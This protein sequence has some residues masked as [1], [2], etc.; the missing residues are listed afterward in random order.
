MAVKQVGDWL[1]EFSQS[2]GMAML[3]LRNQLHSETI[4]VEAFP[5]SMVEQ[6]EDLAY[7]LEKAKWFYIMAAKR[8]KGDH[9][10]DR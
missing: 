1:L 10:D 5:R 4:I 9:D 6:V 3:V 8:E 2:E 7:A